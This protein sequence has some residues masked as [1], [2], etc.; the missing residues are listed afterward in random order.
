M[1]TD[2]DWGLWQALAG[3]IEIP[4]GICLTPDT[5]KSGNLS[6]NVVGPVDSILQ[7]QNINS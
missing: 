3:T 4:Q 1:D 5:I 2:Q 6:K 7:Q